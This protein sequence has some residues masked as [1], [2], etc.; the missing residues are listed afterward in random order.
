[1]RVRYAEE[2]FVTLGPQL[3]FKKNMFQGL[4]MQLT[5]VAQV[6]Q[7]MPNM[8]QVPRLRESQTF[9]HA[10]RIR[11]NSSRTSSSGANA[12]RPEVD[13]DEQV[14]SQCKN[15]CY[16]A[17]EDSGIHE[18]WEDDGEMGVG[19]RLLHLL[20]C[21]QVEN[22]VLLVAR[23][24]DS[25]CGRLIGAELFKL[26][27]EAAKLAL[28]QYYMENVKASDAAKMELMT[29]ATS[30]PTPGGPYQP[31]SVR[32]Q[33]E[34][35]QQHVAVCLMTSDTI[36]SWPV[37]HHPTSDGGGHKRVRQGRINHFL[38]RKAASSNGSKLSK[39]PQVAISIGVNQDD[40]QT[41]DESEG[42]TSD[43]IHA[44]G[45]V[46][47][48][49][50]SRDEL[51]KLKSIRVP[52]KELHYL[53]M[54]LIILLEKPQEK[55][56]KAKPTPKMHEEFTPA[57]FSWM[58]CRD[59]LQQSHTWTERLRD[60]HG[61]DL[62]KSQVTALRAIFQEP[63]F[64]EAAF[65]RISVASVKIFTWLQ[66]LLDEYD[67][68]ELGLLR[69]QDP[70]VLPTAMD[71]SSSS[72]SLSKQRSPNGKQAHLQ[73]RPPPV[74]AS[75]SHSNDDEQRLANEFYRHASKPPKTKIV[76]PGRLFLSTQRGK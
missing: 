55:I 9:P 69:D 23:Q 47:W 48:L 65:I 16:R 56:V 12:G 35:K 63:S 57:N 73:P 44:S 72:L 6:P 21:W 41:L 11:S 76:D 36:P 1:M 58:R 14:P 46:E 29:T 34:Q 51:L 50:V 70:Q 60:L 2:G 30:E 20:Q 61:T 45:G 53:F 5:S 32:R 33:E 24:D 75:A 67:E 43:V 40:H 10:L 49:K 37:K 42:D 18:N 3:R 62:M 4:V 17:S 66:R 25:L 13:G 27:L 59:I 68:M 8:K 38:N 71:A 74:A 7:L 54:C 19:D 31:L 15:P 64:N 26:M 52:V 39:E 28:E 22:V